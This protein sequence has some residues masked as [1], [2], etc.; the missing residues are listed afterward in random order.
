MATPKRTYVVSES[1]G[2]DAEKGVILHAGADPQNL[3]EAPLQAGSA[4]SR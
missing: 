3:L 2:N 4:S 1:T